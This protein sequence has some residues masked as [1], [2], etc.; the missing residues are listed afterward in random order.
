[1]IIANIILVLDL[2]GDLFEELRLEDA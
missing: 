1:M 2:S